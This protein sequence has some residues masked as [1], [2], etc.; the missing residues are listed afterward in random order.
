M[1]IK[2]KQSLITY[3]L[4]R[5]KESHKAARLL[6]ENDMLTSS[7]NR[8]YYAMFYAVQSLLLLH[9]VSFSK[10]SQVKG[11]FNKEFIKNGIFPKDF[12][13]MYNNAFEY[14]QKFDYVDLIIPEKEM[15]IEYIDKANEF[16]N[17]IE[18]YIQAQMKI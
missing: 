2:Y 16:I 12:G 13:R 10:H 7:M 17:T 11:Y 3:R 9:E 6:L 14:R 8:I 15:I 5:S 4:E 1:N 18:R